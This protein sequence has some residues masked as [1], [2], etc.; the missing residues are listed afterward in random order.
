MKGR[1]GSPS[2]PIPAA[3]PPLSSLPVQCGLDAG[4]DFGA[5]GEGVAEVQSGVSP[6]YAHILKFRR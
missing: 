4:L 5:R 3:E 1:D 6:T 2:R